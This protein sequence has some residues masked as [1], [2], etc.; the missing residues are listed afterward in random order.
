MSRARSRRDYGFRR[1]T[2]AC[3]I[4]QRNCEVL[5]G[6]VAPSDL[7]RWRL[8]QGSAFM[9]W[10]LQHL[11]A[12]PGATVRQGDRIYRIPTLV[13]RRLPG[14]RCHWLTLEGRCSIHETAPFGCA[15]FDCRMDQAEGSRRSATALQAIEADHRAGGPYSALW[16]LLH[17]RGLTA[18]GPGTIRA[19]EGL[20]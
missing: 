16:R 18:E 14:G 2:C 8:E 4:C 7:E 12:S 17:A 19:R 13:P 6:M 15:M 11:A 9:A 20:R 5:S 3:R 1:V 10:A